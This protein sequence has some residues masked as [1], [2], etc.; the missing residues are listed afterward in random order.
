MQLDCQPCFRRL[1]T[2]RIRS[3]E[4]SGIAGRI[5]EARSL[6]VVFV[7][8]IADVQRRAAGQLA[9]SIHIEEIVPHEVQ[10]AT[11]RMLDAVEEVIYD[12]VAVDPV[13]VVAGINRESGT[14]SPIQRRSEHSRLDADA[15]ILEGNS[16]NLRWVRVV[17][18]D[19]SEVNG[20]LVRD[21]VPGLGANIGVV[22]IAET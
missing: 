20:D 12:R 21:R 3:D 15:E 5:G 1:K 14:D 4:E 9:H 8:S 16:R 13:V 18:R 2:H 6:P 22:V 11:L 19:Q 17:S 10:A 7:D